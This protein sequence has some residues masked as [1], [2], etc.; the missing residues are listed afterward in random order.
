LV[1]YAKSVRT[2]IPAA[3]LKQLKDLLNHDD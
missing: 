2:S 3:V 1:I